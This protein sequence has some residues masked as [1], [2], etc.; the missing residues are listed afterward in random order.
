M[1]AYAL[2]KVLEKMGHHAEV[3][4]YTCSQIQ[5]DLKNSS[6][7]KNVIKKCFYLKKILADGQ[8]RPSHGGKAR[9]GG[10]MTADIA[11]DAYLPREMLCTE[12]V[13]IPSRMVRRPQVGRV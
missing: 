6:K 4:D 10:E 13:T 3:V 9:R 1:Q 7:T 11:H 12:Q 8:R 5:K 2:V